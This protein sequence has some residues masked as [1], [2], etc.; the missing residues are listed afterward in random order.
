MFKYSQP[1]TLLVQ[2]FLITCLLWIGGYCIAEF[3]RERRGK[4]K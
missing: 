3:K 1:I 2:G 4:T